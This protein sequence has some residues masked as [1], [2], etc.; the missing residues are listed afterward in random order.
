M[1]DVKN[2]Y[3]VL[4]SMTDQAEASEMNSWGEVHVQIKS[5]NHRF[6]DIKCR[7]PNHLQMAEVS[8]RK[9]LENEFK[10][11]SFDVIVNVK[12]NEQYSVH[13]RLNVDRIAT[14]LKQLKKIDFK[15]KETIDLT[16][17]L[18]SEFIDDIANESFQTLQ[19]TL[20]RCMVEAMKT[21]L[22]QRREEGEKIR[23]LLLN[24]HQEIL[25][26]LQLIKEKKFES[27]DNKKN[28]LLVKIKEL[29]TGMI[30]EQRL[31]QEFVILA[32]K[33]DI[34]EELDRFDIHCNKLQ[35]LLAKTYEKLDRGKELEFTLQELGRE[36]NTMSNKSEHALI[37]QECVSIKVLL[38]NIREQ[39]L[40]LE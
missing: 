34:Q 13:T 11:G 7:L 10:R 38:E 4:S 29:N 36:I 2:R 14:Y 3:F 12:Y 31:A 26:H 30:D 28:K 6:K 25:E 23:L 18:R 8:L 37:S 21:L 20:N 33:L 24:Y 1:L 22:Q 5:L 35:N 16:A 27:L 15:G 32:Q 17:F 39:I 40:N 19:A 9:M